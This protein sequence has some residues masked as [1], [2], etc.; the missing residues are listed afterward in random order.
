MTQYNFACLDEQTKRTIYRAILIGLAI[1]GCRVPIA[2][3]LRFLEPSEVETHKTHSLEQYGLMHVKLIEDMQQHG[4]IGTAF[5]FRPGRF[6]VTRSIA[7][8]PSHQ[9]RSA[10]CI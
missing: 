2:G 7:S 6:E 8:Q 10:M 3:P 1:P 4:A 5:A 9:T